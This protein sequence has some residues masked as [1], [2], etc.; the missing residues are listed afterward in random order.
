MVMK[1]DNMVTYDWFTSADMS[2]HTN[3]SHHSHAKNPKRFLCITIAFGLLDITNDV[4]CGF[5]L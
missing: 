5:R 1:I 4:K 3:K 2:T